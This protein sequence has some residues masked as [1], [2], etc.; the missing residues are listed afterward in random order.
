M[1][2]VKILIIDDE[3]GSRQPLKDLFDFRGYDVLVAAGGQEG[4][5]I[6][7][8]KKPDVIVL[9]WLMPVGWGGLRV[10]HELRG[11]AET[12]AIPVIVFSNV[13][14]DL[15]LRL[16]A[17]RDGAD[18]FLPK[19]LDGV[20]NVPQEQGLDMLEAAVDQALKRDAAIKRKTRQGTG[21]FFADVNSRA[22]VIDGAR[23]SDLT[24]KEFAL[25]ELLARNPG[26]VLSRD[27]IL[28]E[29]YPLETYPN[30]VEQDRLEALVTRL[31]RKIQPDPRGPRY[32]TTRNGLGYQL[33]EP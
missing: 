29:L 22:A 1:A 24:R 17:K 20:V 4:V 11:K 15:D 30:G 10:L 23:I 16:L 25:F 18:D 19:N 12:E 31:R 8:A 13:G 2:A 3:R 6:A 21:F 28:E 33:N 14:N 7:Q 27:D 26:E 32:L 9:D 5:A